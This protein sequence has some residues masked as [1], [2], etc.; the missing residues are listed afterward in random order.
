MHKISASGK[1]VINSQWLRS[2][3][4]Y[5]MHFVFLFA[6]RLK[7]KQKS[8]EYMCVCEENRTQYT[9]VK[10]LPFLSRLYKSSWSERLYS[11]IIHK[12]CWFVVIFHTDH[13]FVSHCDLWIFLVPVIYY[14]WEKSLLQERKKKQTRKA[15]TQQ[16]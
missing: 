11:V 9:Y 5:T 6:N 8:R 14:V 7:N 13:I 2:I 12:P 4:S 15:H 10:M 1:F 3:Y 16:Q